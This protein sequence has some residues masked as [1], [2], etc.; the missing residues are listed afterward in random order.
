MAP[1]LISRVLVRAPLLPIAALGRAAGTIFRQPLPAA[2][3]ALSNPAL[4]DK[5]SGKTARALGNYA[6]RAAFR[7]TPHGLWAGVGVGRLG[8]RT[9][10]DTGAPHAH[11]TVA[12]GR[13]AAFG[14]ALLDDPRLRD[15]VRLRVAPSL[16]ESAGAAEWLAFGE[17]LPA[18]A[19]RTDLD[20]TL[21]AVL[22]SAEEWRAWPEVRAA[23]AE[24]EA[25]DADALDEYLR[26]LVDD[27]LLVHD[28]EP[29]LVGPPPL[30]WMRARLSGSS[31][32]LDEVATLLDGAARAPGAAI[33]AA[34]EALARLPGGAAEPLH[35]V[36][37]FAPKAEPQVSRVA[38]ERAAGL[39]E[40]LTRLQDALVP[41][42]AERLLDPAIGEALDGIT[43]VFGAGALDLQALAAG[44]YGTPLTGDTPRAGHAPPPALLA[45]LVDRLLACAHAGAGEVH[46]SAAELDAVTPPGATPPTCELVLTPMRE[47]PRTPAGTGWLLALHAP[48]G[49]SWGRFAGAVGA[50]LEAAL[51]ELAAAEQSARPSETRLDVAFAPTRAL[52]DLAVHPPVRAGVLALSGS[53]D[54]A[55]TPAE[56]ELCADAAAL[57]PLALR[58]GDAQVVPSPLHRLR[59]TTAA[60]GVWQLLTGWSLQRQHAPWA[61]SLGP[62]A[63]LARLPR[64]S[65]EGFVVAPA[66]WQ[67]PEVADRRALAAWR[68]RA[69]VPRRVQVGH[70]DELLLIDLMSADALEE[71]RRLPRDATRPR[72]FEVWPPLERGVDRAGRRVEIVAAMVDAPD[73][74]EAERLVA[75]SA[76]VA[77][78]GRVPPPR[79]APPAEGWRTFKLFGAADRADRVLAQI[80][81]PEV[82]AAR[83]AGELDGWFFMRYVD[84]PGRRDHLRV[85]VH[86]P[87]KGGADAFAARLTEA[88]AP[89]RAAGDVVALEIA[90]YHREVARYGADAIAAVERLFE[91]D[92]ALVC[93]L[94]DED[95]EPDADATELLVRSL[96]V[97]AAGL[98]LDLAERRE[99]ARR[100]RDAYAAVPGSNDGERDPLAAEFRAR[101]A[102][103]QAVLSAT[104]LSPPF[105]AQRARVAVAVRKLSEARRRA[106]LPALLH[107]A[108]VRLAGADRQ[109]EAR[110]VYFWERTLDGLVHRAR[111]R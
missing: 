13:L 98:G 82:R 65:I 107:L 64:I 69:G 34:R 1:R 76:A 60:P 39:A 11:L 53:C 27:G 33:A 67:L 25:G 50:P 35:A 8:P 49:A 78:M 100:R 68:K 85:R 80:V 12:W 19:R 88:L 87:E 63:G 7:A 95:A 96:D 5:K 93:D 24:R 73:W 44:D 59:S 22:A 106:I 47:P 77:K 70:E 29:P 21:A 75:A 3:L 40:L 62:L 15:R 72:A 32:E 52:A 83:A 14:R 51:G 45:L 74:D 79:L 109:A 71:L 20:E 43:E 57:D 99:L 17:E 58:R 38:V 41:P 61:L 90:G 16:L 111:R 10:I 28:L 30:E 94:L 48:A 54:R 110:A 42:A 6:R 97:L 18:R 101:Q 91:A 23:L 84:G 26:V 89:A 66:S 46:F 55:V 36:L 86:E 56:L 108:A 9:R 105:A 103:L 2:A 81:A 104:P 31:P 102:R 4:L 92:S 37:V